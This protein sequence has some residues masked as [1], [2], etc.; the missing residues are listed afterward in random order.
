MTVISYLSHVVS[1]TLTAARKPALSRRFQRAVQMQSGDVQVV[2]GAGPVNTLGWIDTDIIWRAPHYLDL[3]KPW[4]VPA[5]SVHLVYA[6][7]VIEH[8]DL[9]TARVVLRNMYD[10]VA[11]GG[12]IR[13]ATPDVERTAR[14]YL[15]G[16]DRAQRHLARHRSRGH[17]AVHNC[18]LLRLTYVI[19]EH[20]KGYCFDFSALSAEVE[21]AGFVKVHREEVGESSDRRFAQLETRMS[22]TEQATTLI[23]E[24][25]RP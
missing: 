21:S 11:P 7:N 1:A 9:H 23:V 17:V 3:T 24:A 13:L 12:V 16:G 10:A 25:T 6:D 19:A 14:M 5:G 2:V 15:D 20:Y 8:F 4:P 22:E 18:D